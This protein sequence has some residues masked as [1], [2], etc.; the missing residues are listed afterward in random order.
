MT[1]Y[2]TAK[3]AE[4]A[5]LKKM[6]NIVR[7]GFINC[8]QEIVVGSPVESGRFR[9]NWQASINTPILNTIHDEIAVKKY[10]SGKNKG[11]SNTSVFKTANVSQQVSGYTSLDDVLYLTNNLPY[12]VRLENGWSQQRGAGWVAQSVEN[13][14][15]NIKAASGT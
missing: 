15:A 13:A 8:A 4:A 14:K 10:K 5:M 12:A 3:E 1:K 2:N 11:K 6:T 9:A 7:A